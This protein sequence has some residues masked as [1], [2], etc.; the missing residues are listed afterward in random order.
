MGN[1]WLKNTV[2]AV[3]PLLGIL[4]KNQI[5]TEINVHNVYCSFIKKI[6]LFILFIYF[7]LCWVFVAAWASHCSGFSC[8]GARALGT[9]VSVVAASELS[10]CGSRALEHRLSSCSTRDVIAPQHVGSSQTRD[11]THVPCIGR[12]ILNHCT[13]REA[14]LLHFLE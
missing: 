1:N 12:R 5:W 4:Q 11:R 7:W 8:C 3:I 2:F 6:N 9:R 13:T 10:S 14:L